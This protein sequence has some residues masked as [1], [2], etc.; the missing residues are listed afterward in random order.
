LETDSEWKREEIAQYQSESNCDKCKGQRLKEEALCVKIN[1]L[2][3]SDVT[4]KSI[5]DA[6]IWFDNLNSTT[7]SQR[8]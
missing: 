5:D 4:K 3:I 6:K 7:Y 1:K 8:N 2:N